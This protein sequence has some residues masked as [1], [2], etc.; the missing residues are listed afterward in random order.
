MSFQ[1][2]T[3]TDTK[4]VSQ[5]AY[6]AVKRM[7]MTVTKLWLSFPS[8]LLSWSVECSKHKKTKPL[9]VYTMS[10]DWNGGITTRVYNNISAEMMMKN[11]KYL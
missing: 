9:T 6:T 1:R 5:F 10:A 11:R 4:S 8:L 7:I 2:E 3:E